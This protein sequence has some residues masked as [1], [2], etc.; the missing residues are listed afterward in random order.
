[1]S[2]RRTIFRGVVT[3]VAAAVGLEAVLDAV[4]DA[5]LGG[6][7]A[8]LW[9]DLLDVPLLLALAWVAARVLTSRVARP[10]R[11]LTSL[12]EALARNP[13]IRDLP[14][15]D[16]RDEVARVQ[17]SLA[18]LSRNVQALIAREQAFT[19]YA[20]HELRTPVGALKVQLER[21]ALGSASAED[22][23]PSLERQ[24][25]RI[26]ELLAALLTLARARERD[27]HPERVDALLRATLDQIP[28]GDRARVH[29]IDPIPDG[30]IGSAALVRAALRNLIEN[31]LRHAQGV[32]AVVAAVEGRTLTLQVRDMGPGLPVG[33]LRRL[34]DPFAERPVRADGHGLG[35]TLVSLIARA[36]DGK[37]LLQNT[38]IGLEAT[39]AVEV[40][41]SAQPS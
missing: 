21:V 23:I 26:E 17:R 36:L 41:E 11:E 25:A 30:R 34:S 8:P 40:V 28:E 9:L 13:S 2:L 15:P 29:L 1:M 38:G 14:H 39:L 35:L 12:A 37:L 33:E 27:E 22:V 19:R 24:V 16:G 18:S 31:G 4:A 5:S 3:T 7:E 20:S 10:L 6:A 32:T